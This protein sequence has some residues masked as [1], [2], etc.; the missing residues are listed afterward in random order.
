[1][2]FLSFATIGQDEI[3]SHCEF[4]KKNESKNIKLYGDQPLPYIHTDSLMVIQPIID[5][6][7]MTKEYQMIRSIL[8]PNARLL[9]YIETITSD[10]QLHDP[11]I[12]V[13][14]RIGD[15]FLVYKNDIQQHIIG[16][17]RNYII[18]LS[19]ENEMPIL[20]IADS[21]QLKQHVHDLCKVTTINPIH[22]G[23]LDNSD[24]DD[25]LM[26]TLAEFFMMSTASKIYCINFYDGSG[27]SRICSKIYSPPLEKWLKLIKLNTICSF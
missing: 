11:Y 7:D 19:K 4:I 23:S 22:T 15:Q 27:Y 25:R 12:I 16:K 20:F 2:I 26:A 13:H 9:S 10:I 6:V 24:V 5:N 21:Y 18:Q 1:M 8:T 14:A 3:C 17:I